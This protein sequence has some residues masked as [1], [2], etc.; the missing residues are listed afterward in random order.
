[1]N[2]HGYEFIWEDWKNNSSSKTALTTKGGKKYFL[3]RYTTPVAP[4]NNGSLTPK[5]ME[6]NQR[7]F[8]KF[9]E[10][11]SSINKEIRKFAASGG[12]IIIPA[13]EFVDE[14]AYVEASEWIENV[15]KDDDVE[16]V[17]KTLTPEVKMNLLLTAT[18]ALKTIHAHNIIHSDLKLK[19]ILLA[20]NM[21][22]TY[23]ARLID[24]D[25]SYFVGKL[26]DELVGDINYYSPELGAYKEVYEDAEEDELPALGAN[27]TTKSDVFS[28]GLIFHY[29]LTGEFVTFSDL[30]PPLQARAAA[31]K[32]IFP[33]VVANT[34][35]KIVLNEAKIANP[36]FVQLI[37]A[38]L[39]KDYHERPDSSE[40][41]MALKMKKL[42][43]Q[44]DKFK[45]GGATIGGG[46]TGES[47]GGATVSTGSTSGVSAGPSIVKVAVSPAMVSVDAGR[48]VNLV[49]AVT[50]TGGASLAVTWSSSN[51]GVATVNASGT[52]TGV[53]P[54]NAIITA[55]SAADI[56]KKGTCTVS[57]KAVGITRPGVF[58]EPWPEH[59]IEF[60]VDKMRSRGI[61]GL[62]REE[63]GG[64]KGYGLYSDL[65]QATTLFRKVEI[66]IA[67]GYAK[68]VEKRVV[69]EPGE[70]C[71][72]YPEHGIVF[73]EEAIRGKNYVKVERNDATKTYRFTDKNGVVRD[74]NPQ[75][76]VILKLA[77]RV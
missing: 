75:M 61:L 71:E 77:K 21:S 36:F 63:Q 34:G 30:I 27:L 40:V 66:L 32:S 41:Y 6:L 1:M 73:D 64:V 14:N 53:A 7:K 54:G 26:P 16:N 52:V 48:T 57:V 58:E 39:A 38:M 62:V 37:N 15:V 68:K 20:K 22:G 74:L 29:Y 72:P 49:P 35:G 12:D 69:V 9:V 60:N 51:P 59:S 5:A 33:W 23:S 42:G 19:N 65:H 13:A 2:V 55:T 44:Y 76:C 18:G 43:P 70:I 11:R 67:I 24:F 46:S 28:M 47:T 17:L 8:D 10:I 31:G 50:A 3:K 25:N 56:T 45:P 4:I